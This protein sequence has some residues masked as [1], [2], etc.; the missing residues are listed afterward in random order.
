MAKAL[1]LPMI[2]DEKKECTNCEIFRW[3][4]PSDRSTLKRCSGCQLFWYCSKQ[5]QKEH[6]LNTH[7]Y[8]CKYLFSEK[9]LPNAKHNDATCL[10]CKEEAKAGK[11]NMSKPTN[12]VLPC[13][14][15]TA[16]KYLIGISEPVGPGGLPQYEEMPAKPLAEMTEIYHTKLDATFA[17]MMRIL[18][19]MKMTNNI[20]W[21]T[22]KS[23]V[24]KLYR[25]LGECR[26]KEW[27][28]QLVTK[29]GLDPQNKDNDCDDI[30]DEL[31]EAVT[32]IDTLFSVV[33]EPSPLMP[34]N[35]FKTLKTFCFDSKTMEGALISDHL[36]CSN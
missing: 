9:V 4:Q 10:V 3:K 26:L 32:Y 12:P 35:T 7:K 36:G 23:S 29:L 31:V 14:M 11:G 2:I 15:S 13:Y 33:P 24:K 1:P 20:I 16:N 28:M 30:I 22:R 6:W 27:L 34:W 8:H 19:K 25:I 21:M 18:V 17:I 5:C